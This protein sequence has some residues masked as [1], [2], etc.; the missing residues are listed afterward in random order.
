MIGTPQETAEIKIRGDVVKGRYLLIIFL[1]S[2]FLLGITKVVDTDAWMHLSIGREIFNLKGLPATEP[3]VY[4]MFGKPFAYS[5]W[6]FALIY[7]MAY[8]AFNVYGVILLKAI[9]IT[10]AFYILIRDS[11]LPK[12]NYI[13]SIAVMSV[14]V[15]MARY[16]FVVR[17]DTF[18]MM[19]LP[20]S[21]YALNAYI[22]ENKKYI[23]AL[24]FV[25]MLWANSHSSI[26]LMFVPFLSFIVG[27]ILQQYISKKLNTHHP[28]PVTYFPYTPTTAQLKTI[29]LVFLASFAASL[30]SPYFITQ[31]TAGAGVMASDWWKQE[32]MELAKPTWQTNKWP[33]LMTAAIA[34]SFMLNWFSAYRS[35]HNPPIPPL[36]KGGKGGFEPS[37]IHLFLVIPFVVLSFTALRFVFLLGIVS[38][39]VLARNLSIFI[40]DSR[41]LKRLFHKKALIAVVSAWIILYTALGLSG[42]E[43]FGNKATAFGF[44]FD[45]SFVPEGAMKYMD[46]R[47]ITGRVFNLFQWGQY[48]TWRDFPKRTA[49]VDGRGYLPVDLLEKQD[50][51]RRRP[52]VL[53]ELYKRYRFKS[54]LVEYPVDDAG[55][56]DVLYN[57]DLA[58]SDPRWALVYWDDLSLVY[59]KRGGVYDSIIKK[60]EYRFVKPA[61]NISGTRARLHDKNYRENLIRELK[62]NIKETGSSKAY[63]FLGFVYNE[64]GRYR[65]AI[66]VFSKVKDVPGLSHLLDAYSGIAY[67]YGRLGYMDKS[68]LYYKK[69][70]RLKNNATTLYNIGIAYIKKR[71]E[72]K[73]I[74]YLSEALSLNSNLMSV[75]PQLIDIYQRFGM[76]QEVEKTLKMYEKAR[77]QGEGGEYF[78]KGI[79]TYLNNRP[80]VAAEWFEKSIRANPSN[81]APY[82]NLGYIYF[83]MG[84]IDR[85]YEYQKRALD[86]DPDFANAHYGLALIYKKLGD[87]EKAVREYKEYLRIEPAGYYSR[88]A[89]KA[90]EAME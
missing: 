16:R 77:V 64:T 7:Y 69:S 27:G 59:L 72:K 30:I 39:P 89:K 83:D 6:L 50:L 85:A 41:S 44:G 32:I 18:L 68:I 48:I 46:K 63:A 84:V 3:F 42:V 9:T 74:K 57:T 25:D 2:L 67:A 56:S 52:S 43:P 79:K 54:I 11:L 37:L 90:I 87:T 23:Y 66:E 19:F 40:D 88:R 26:N 8:L 65:K 82:S 13:V 80:D 78:K 20:F 12:K 15:I 34:V 75:Y 58:L 36:A 73:A 28:S 33:F 31:Y 24:P 45:Y 22:Y 76:K 51:A 5:S 62:R 86:I 1:L 70:L 47:N 71:D 55:I 61:N 14:I 81:P 17:P 49:F 60:D 38:G 53:D 10:A 35:R 4:P 29:T 21:I